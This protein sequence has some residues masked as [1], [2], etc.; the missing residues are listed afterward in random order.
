MIARVQF[1]D[2]ADIPAGDIPS[3]MALQNTW[4]ILFSDL[5]LPNF[6]NKRVISQLV[7]E[8]SVLWLLP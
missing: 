4:C 2:G 3:C 1:K 8:H 7:A 6:G 5:N